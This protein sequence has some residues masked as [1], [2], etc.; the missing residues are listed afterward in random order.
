[1][2]KLIDLMKKWRDEAD[3]AETII[4]REMLRYCASDL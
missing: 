1:M 3:E 2:T 4:G